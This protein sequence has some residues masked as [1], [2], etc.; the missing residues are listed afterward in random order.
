MSG[1]HYGDDENI[2]I[3]GILVTNSTMDLKI[4]NKKLLHPKLTIKYFKINTKR[5][6]HPPNLTIRGH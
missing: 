3:V 6:L 1:Q 5:K 2:I 4:G